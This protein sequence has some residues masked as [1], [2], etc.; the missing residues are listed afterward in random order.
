MI[1]LALIV[2]S[3]LMY[4]A[5]KLTLKHNSELKQLREENARLKAQLEALRKEYQQVLAQG[6][7]SVGWGG[8]KITDAQKLA[9]LAEAIR[10][11][12]PLM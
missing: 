2:A 1:G 3:F 6:H 12:E 7:W 5:Y 11:K 9:Q 8:E 10:R 4:K